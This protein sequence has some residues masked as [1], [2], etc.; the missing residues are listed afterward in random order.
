M[1]SNEVDSR[2][3]RA[4]SSLK[5]DILD[6]IISDSKQHTGKIIN[7]EAAKVKKPRYPYYLRTAAVLLVCIMC[8]GGLGLYGRAYAVKS[9]VTVDTD[10][11]IELKLNRDEKV[12]EARALAPDSS[13]MVDSKSLEGLPVENAMDLILDSALANGS[14]S[15]DENSLLLS[16][17]SKDVQ[18][19]RKLSQRLNTELYT[20]LKDKGFDA[21]VMAQILEENEEL[22]ALSSDLNIS[23]GKARLVNS[24]STGSTEFSTEAL[25]EMS[26]NNLNI[27]LNCVGES[28]NDLNIIGDA[29][30]GLYLDEDAAKLAVESEIGIADEDFR[31]LEMSLGIENGTLVY[32]M[33][34]DSGIYNYSCTVDALSGDI[35]KRSEE[36]SEEFS[37]WLDQQNE[38][39]R[40]WVSENSEKLQAFAES[41]SEDLRSLV[42]ECITDLCGRY[43]QYG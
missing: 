18:D 22:S 6:S 9:T 16:V 21:S 25:A 40:N 5:P 14:I 32:S 31:N 3:E 19:A 7:I 41:S 42:V 35:Y 12:I 37:N 29:S 24:I 13:C 28:P 34:F 26:I 15:A 27:I 38:G 1:N 23:T 36:L 8:F 30:M 10:S 33:N 39:V 4:F 2:V 11:A 43:A 17:E 20:S